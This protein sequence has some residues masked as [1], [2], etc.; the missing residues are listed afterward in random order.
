MDSPERPRRRWPWL[1]LIFAPVLLLAGFALLS[2]RPGIVE[3]RLAAI[4]AQ[5]LPTHLEELD[6]WLGTNAAAGRSNAAAVEIIG[7]KLRVDK[8][9]PLPARAGAV[10]EAEV[11][12]PGR[13]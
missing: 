2:Q 10:T 6:R 1:L 9:R 3:K 11:A 12:W 7:E 13:S 5:G 4:R 8:N